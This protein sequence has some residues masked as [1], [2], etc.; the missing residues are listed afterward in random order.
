MSI[1]RSR[2]IERGGGQKVLEEQHG[3]HGLEKVTGLVRKKDHRQ[4]R[5]WREG[6]GGGGF[7]STLP[8]LTIRVW[9][10]FPCSVKGFPV[11]LAPYSKGVP[12]D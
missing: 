10:I 5:S 3:R 12:Y 2:R 4:G 6:L 1:Q 8:F 11:L 9:K 7:Y